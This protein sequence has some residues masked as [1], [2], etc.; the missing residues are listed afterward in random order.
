MDK[1]INFGLNA[2]FRKKEKLRS[3]KREH[4]QI[5]D[6]LETNVSTNRDA[7]TGAFQAVDGL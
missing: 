4:R 7:N 2:G 5:F 1:P 3:I 6:Q